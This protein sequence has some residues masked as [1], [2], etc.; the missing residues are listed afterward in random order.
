MVEGMIPPTVILAPATT[1]PVA[2]TF[3]RTLACR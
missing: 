1:F 3:A 2:A